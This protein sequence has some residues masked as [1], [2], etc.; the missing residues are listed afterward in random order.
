MLAIK[1]IETEET[2]ERWQFDILQESGPSESGQSVDAVGKGPKRKEKEKG[3]NE[4]QGEIRDGICDGA[5]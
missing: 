3:L 5:P 2:L 1:S 4:V